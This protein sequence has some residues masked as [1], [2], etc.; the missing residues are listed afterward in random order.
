MEKKQDLLNLQI[1]FAIYQDS[2]LLFKTKNFKEPPY[3]REFY[4]PFIPLIHNFAFFQYKIEENNTTIIVEK[5]EVDDILENII[6]TLCTIILAIFA[7]LLFVTNSIVNSILIPI[8]QLNRDIKRVSIDNFKSSLAKTKFNDEIAQLRDNFNA[9]VE[10]L[11][12]GVARLKRANDTIAHELK[13]PITIMQGEIE[14]ALTQDRTSSYYKER[15]LKLQ[16]QL[17]NLELLVKTLLILSRYSKEEIKEQLELCDFNA[18]LLTVLEEIEPFAAKKSI[19][20]NIEEFTKASK[21]SNQELLYSIMK[22]I[23]ENAI[24]YSHENSQVTISLSQ[25]EDKIYFRVKD[26]GIG[27]AKEDIANI[28]E[29]FFKVAHNDSSSFGLGLS[30]VQ[31]ASKL[32]DAKLTIQSTLHKGS[33]CIVEF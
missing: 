4:M 10:R 30:I 22:N 20:L 9:M 6:V 14:L 29:R 16:K 24:K 12:S 8:N 27:I 5:L 18:V 32:L 7:I 23:I 17:Q 1:P 28:T 21:L 11:N 33:E 13:T 15:F 31:E 3:R 2:K 25:K 26:N 19:E